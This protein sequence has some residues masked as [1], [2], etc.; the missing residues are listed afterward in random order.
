VAAVLALSLGSEDPILRV[1][2]LGAA[3]A[4]VATRRRAGARLRPVLVAV[5]GIALLTV[6]F[7]LLLSHTGATVLVTLPAWL[8]A[9]GGALTLEGAAYGLDLAAGL[10]AC[11]VAGISLSLVIEPFQMVDSLP[12]FLSRTGAA[13]GAAMTL[14]PRLGRSFGSVR[15]AQ[16]MRGWQ[17][18]GLRSWTAVVVPAV[19]TTI[20]G[21][22]LLAES[23][24][25]RAFGS[26]HRTASAG[27]GWR[28]TDVVIAGTSAAVLVTFIAALGFGQVP[29][30]HPYPA[31]TLPSLG[32]WPF[33]TCLGLFVPAFLG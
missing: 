14:V 2:T 24:E 8:P 16:Q 13:L 1:L 3:L 10:A 29:V 4:V 18:H 22:V 15:E 26:G 7:N 23:M 9:V 33:L 21:S 20:E 5:G 25:A 19:L 6:I 28:T 11:V 27:P 17:P 30:W 32:W 12:G 31:L